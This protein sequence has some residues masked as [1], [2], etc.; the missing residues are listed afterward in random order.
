MSASIQ[1]TILTRFTAHGGNVSAVMG[2]MSRGVGN[3][4]NQV[5]QANRVSERLNNVWKAMGTTLRYTLAGGIIFG[6]RNAVSQ[7]AGIQKQMG[8][9]SAIGSFEGPGGNNFRLQGQELQRFGAELRNVAVDARTPLNDMNDAAINFLSTVQGVKSEEISPMLKIISQA[10]QLAQVSSEDATK[11]FTTLNTAFGRPVNLKGIQQMAQEFFI[12]TQEAPGGKEAGKQLIGQMGQL[13]NMTKL[14]GG[15]PEDM[16]SLLLSGLRGGIPPAQVGRGLQFML[17]TIALPGAQTKP[18][19]KALAEV[20][21]TPGV[22]MSA[23][24]RLTRI[25]SHARG[26]GMGKGQINKIMGLDEETLASLE[27]TDTTDALGQVG[28]HGKGA[29]F[30]GQIFRRIHALRMALAISGQVDVGQAQQDLITMQDVIDGHVSDVNDIKKAWQAYAKNTNLQAAAIAIEAMQMQTMEAFAPVF[31]FLARG[32]QFAQKQ[33][34]KHQEGVTKAE[35]ILAGTIAGVGAARF[36]GLGRLPGIRNIPGMG[37]LLTGGY[38]RVVEANAAQSLAMHGG[39]L[40]SSP[41]N[42]IY[43]VIVYDL[44]KGISGGYSPTAAVGGGGGGIAG[45]AGDAA[46]GYG[47]VKLLQKLFGKGGVKGNLLRT[48]ARGGLP[49]LGLAAAATGAIVGPAL[50]ANWLAGGGDSRIQH[51]NRPRSRQQIMAAE[52]RFPRI[53]NF[54][55]AAYSRKQP[56]NDRYQ[57]LLM[58]FMQGQISPRAVDRALAQGMQTDTG[59]E[60]ALYVNI[61]LKDKDGQ[62]Q[63]VTVKVPKEMWKN[64]AIPSSRGRP[65]K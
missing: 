33:M 15:T 49:A 8:L 39:A 2:G 19:Q 9:I 3:F 29:E 27:E 63:K 59:M 38:R 61:T 4:S 21:I 41:S 64:K 35:R 45:E 56:L 20:G 30:L 36:L 10:A 51:P 26:L 52:E 50:L 55:D 25:L 14:A 18:A 60:R 62:K 34:A 48:G 5:N 28:V 16:F 40:G 7:F 24:E 54:I 32:P 22:E 11:A 23:Q 44:Y 57:K 37:S 42:P 12:L 17:Q 43:A 13:A 53:K 47:E 58:M 65:G 6:L 31:N 46:K 1:N